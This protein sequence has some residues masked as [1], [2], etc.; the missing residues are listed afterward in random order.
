MLRYV[1]AVILS[2]GAV[3]SPARAEVIAFW[4][5]NSHPPDH[6]T[7]TGTLQPA[8]GAGTAFLVGGVTASF[9]AANGASD[10]A[11][12]DSN[13]R[14]T[15]WPNQGVGNKSHG[16]RFNVNL[17]GY[18]NLRLTWDQRNSNTASKYARLQ[19]TTNGTDFLDYQVIVMPSETW[20]HN[21]SVNFAA[22]PG[23]D[24]NPAFGVRVVTEFEHTATGT[25]VNG[26]VPSNPGSSYG[27]NGTLRF[28]MVT[29]FAEPIGPNP[30]PTISVLNYN[31][32]GAEKTEWTTNTVQVQAIGRQLAHLAPD[33]VTLQEIPNIGLANMSHFVSAYLP[34]YFLATNRVSD[35]DKGNLILSR[36]P[37]VRSRSN[38]GR[39]SLEQWGFDGVFTRDLFEAEIAVPG[40]NEL[41]HVYSI[42]LKAFN[43]PI[44]SPRR[45]AE[46]SAVSNYFVTVF[47]PING[48]RPYLLAG[49]FNEDIARPRSYEQGAM[50]RIIGDATGLVLT[51]PRNPFNGD[52]RTW[53]SRN[54]TP[55]IRFDYILP[56][57]LLAERIVTNWIFRT[58]FL[59][60]PPPGLQSD[61]SQIATDHLPLL[62]VFRNPYDLPP[63]LPLRV[64]L[65]LTNQTVTLAWDSNPGRHYLV[66]GSFNLTNW[67]SLSPSIPA[68]GTNTTWQGSIVPG[69]MFFR[70]AEG[71]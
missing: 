62:T 5:F 38:L 54:A 45:A 44:S 12:D 40:F 46:A 8:I 25:G 16:V 36:F 60:P 34:G 47:R 20:V 27:N 50:P 33:I 6:T 64:N 24:D 59:S 19:Y 58:D 65:Q 67:I 30:Q 22:V 32:W 66:Q 17:S 4:N 55:T 43:D 29:F 11:I 13:W 28:D 23:V 41:L 49:D 9:T 52:E 42:H 26:Y 2:L 69:G 1:L 57:P 68:N 15:T 61:D 10:T 63:A 56:G 53:S 18:R 21:H 3:N 37:I 31:V 48:H 35:G 14:I 7:D 39:S 51:T 70:I 71:P